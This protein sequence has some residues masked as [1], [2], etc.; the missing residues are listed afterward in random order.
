MARVHLVRHARPAAGWDA[1]PDPGLDERGRGQADAVADRLVAELEP[2]PVITSPLRRTRQTAAPLAARWRTAAAV[3]VAV[4][5]I[6]SPTDDLAERRRWLD[7]VLAGR[8]DALDGA[9]DRWRSGVLE[10]VRSIE[11]DTV[12]VTHFVAVNAVVAE[13]LG[14]PDVCTFLPGHASVTVVDVGPAGTLEV[15]ELG[16]EAAIDVR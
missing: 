1:D 4:T 16:S 3:D 14:R 10:A 6:P 13:A 11:V 15:V 7:G 12:V 8:W 2:R 9:V 5:E